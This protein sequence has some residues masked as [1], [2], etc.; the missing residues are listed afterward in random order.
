MWSDSLTHTSNNPQDP[1]HPTQT[2]KEE[3]T[4]HALL[5]CSRDKIQKPLKCT[6]TVYTFLTE[7]TSLTHHWR[8]SKGW[9]AGRTLMRK[10]RKYELGVWFIQHKA[11]HE[12]TTIIT[13]HMWTIRRKNKRW[14]LWQKGLW[15]AE[16]SDGCSPLSLLELVVLKNMTF[17][18]PYNPQLKAQTSPQ[19]N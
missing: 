7:A 15:H 11:P 4:P 1:H 9:C 13:T 5:V 10:S 16:P 2:P 19:H 14:M 8:Q 6:G 12:R 17:P 3:H 18:T